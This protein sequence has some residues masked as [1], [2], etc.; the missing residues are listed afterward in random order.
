MSHTRVGK[1]AQ[2]RFLG[3]SVDL[4][5]WAVYDLANTI[6]SAIFLS[7]SFPIFIE[8]FAGGSEQ[9][10]GVVNMVACLASALI[11]PFLGSI[12]DRLGRR[13]P[14]LVGF[15]LMCCVLT[16][17]GT[18]FE[19]SLLTAAI[20]G[21]F[22]I[23]A[24][25]TGLALYDAILP[26]LTGSDDQGR[27]SGLG[28]GIGYGGTV[29]ALLC[30]LLI[31]NR[32]GSGTLPS[33]QAMNWMVGVLFL[34]FALP[35]FILHKETG[36]NIKI[37]WGRLTLES[38]R[39][40]A[41]GARIANRHLWVFLASSFFMVNAMMAV[42]MFFGLYATKEL[43]IAF[44]VFIRIYLVLSL[45]AMFWS[46][47]AGYVVDWVGP[48]RVLIFA[49]FFW[50]GIVLFM[51]QIQTTF[52]FVIAGLAGGAALGLV[53]TAS[54]PLLINLGDP[55]RMGET[56]G[57]LGLANRASAVVGPLVFGTVATHYY[58]DL[59]LQSLIG[60]FALGLFFLFLVPAHTDD[61]LVTP[62]AG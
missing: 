56:F 17:I 41:E 29:I 38:F 3:F 12:S 14:L 19:S 15:T 49:G 1:L 39:R 43:G 60:F 47:V 46:L 20:S 4:W 2:K 61:P 62:A 7:L 37:K 34:L 23:F 40:V 5:A 48:R 25:Y 54:R 59:A 24:Y 31:Q 22:A 30:V 57:F 36:T 21:G 32:F 13:L 50:I 51:M 53:W 35:L 27:A 6:F 44:D 9:H 58:Y 45:S 33:L 8:G 10:V 55:E 52:G 28:I 16:P 26:D 11:V 42:I 18:Y